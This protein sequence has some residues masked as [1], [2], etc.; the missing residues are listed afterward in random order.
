MTAP[1]TQ[2][3]IDALNDLWTTERA[4]IDQ[5]VAR[6]KVCANRGDEV[7]AERFHEFAF[8]EMREVSAILDRI[9]A[10]GGIPQLQQV[11][12][13]P[14]GETPAEQLR[15]SI[16]GEQTT[17]ERLICTLR[18]CQEEGD[19][20]TSS[21]VAE[22]LAREREHLAWLEAMSRGGS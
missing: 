9:V 11:P 15:L 6:S 20:E 21:L 10:L 16:T 8:T 14:V 4:L 13:V 22:D 17:I 12:P 7:L 5:Y 19:I 3:V 18:L 2:R 1:R